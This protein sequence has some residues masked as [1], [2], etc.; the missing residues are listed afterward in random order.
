MIDLI[1]IVFKDSGKACFRRAESRFRF[2]SNELS[3]TQLKKGQNQG[4]FVVDEL[5]IDIPFNVFLY[6]QDTRLVLTDIDGTITESDIKGHI[7]PM[8][9]FTVDHDNVVELFHKIAQNGY[10]MIYL[11]ARSMAQD[12]DTRS[13]LFDVSSSTLFSKVSFRKRV[14]ESELSKASY[15]KRVI[16]SELSEASY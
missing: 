5:H 3:R 9:G 13:Y 11:T 6:D 16:E 12:I 14:L 1:F 15:R 7:F 4:R 10:E 2:T 8:F